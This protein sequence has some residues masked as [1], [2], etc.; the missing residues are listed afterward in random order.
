MVGF[1]ILSIK[2]DQSAQVTKP[3]LSYWLILVVVSLVVMFLRFNWLRESFNLGNAVVSS[4]TAICISLFVAGRIRFTN[5][6]Q[7]ERC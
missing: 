4:I 7:T 2:P 5:Q 3:T 1:F 6:L